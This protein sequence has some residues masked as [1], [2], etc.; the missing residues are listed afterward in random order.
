MDNVDALA[1]SRT[2]PCPICRQPVPVGVSTCQNPN[3]R[4]DLRS[5]AIIDTLPEGWFLLAQQ[6]IWEGKAHR[7]V[8][9]LENVLVDQPENVKAWS[10]L[11][12][13]YTSLDNRD[14]ALRCWTRIAKIEPED[15]RAEEEL[16]KERARQEAVTRRTRRRQ[17]LA[18]VMPSA[19]LLV[20]FLAILAVV[21]REYQPQVS[22]APD[23]QPGQTQALVTSTTTPFPDFAGVVEEAILIDPTFRNFQIQ[24]MQEGRTIL[25]S[26]ELPKQT[27]KNQL[28][29]LLHNLPG[30]FLLDTSNLKVVPPLLAPLVQ[31]KLAG[32][33]QLSTLEI[34]VEQ[35]G[36]SIRLHGTVDRFEA[37]QIAEGLAASVAGVELVDSQYLVFS[38][39]SYVESVTIALQADVRTTCFDITV[40]QEGSTVL[41]S[42]SVYSREAFETIETLVRGIEGIQ[43]VDTSQLII[44]PP[45]SEYTVVTGDNLDSVARKVY[46]SSEKRGLIYEANPEKFPLQPGSVLV[47]P[48]EDLLHGGFPLIDCTGQA[49]GQ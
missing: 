31:E 49:P 29:E 4:V 32:S 28:E 38:P 13:A 18:T 1:A 26:G 46:G 48:P 15:V 2:F 41:L 37:K 47:I 23:E 30:A 20:I 17:L 6:Q 5:L 42:G 35:I 22:T 8:Q 3:C 33:P 25:L 10:T 45:S 36:N 16:A 34:D 19:G 44:T 43:A 21:L 11:A 7:A 24:V 27:L 39:P 12:G 9:I 14:E 40:R